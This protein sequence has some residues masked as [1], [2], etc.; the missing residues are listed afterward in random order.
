MKLESS[1]NCMP[2]SW[3]MMSLMQS[4][5]ELIQ[6]R[7]NFWTTLN[8]LMLWSFRQSLLQRELWVQAPPELSEEALPWETLPLLEQREQL[9]LLLENLL[10][11]ELPKDLPQS[12]VLQ[13]EEAPSDSHFDPALFEL[14]P[15][16]EA[17]QEDLQWEK[18]LQDIEA[19]WEPQHFLL[20]EDH[21]CEDMKRM[22]LF[23]L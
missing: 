2:S 5:E 10:L 15:S 16:T 12:E 3:E 1:V 21:P 13:Q 17:L 6:T 20:E 14:R 8:S 11:E 22:D 9:T 4:S 23:L 18:V 19:P 7:M